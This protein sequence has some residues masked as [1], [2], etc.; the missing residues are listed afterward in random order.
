MRAHTAGALAIGIVLL[1]FLAAGQAAPP[2]DGASAQ[3]PTGTG[4]LRG[5]VVASDTGTP[6]RRAQVRAASSAARTTRLT[7]TDA[8]GRYEVANLP[9]GR[10]T[11][12]VN[13]AG[14]VGL[15]FG[16]RRPFEGG[17]P[18]DLTDGQIAER[19]DFALPRGSVIAGRITDEAGDPIVGAWVQPMR[20]QFGPGGTRSLLPV[21]ASGWMSNITNDLG[22]FR[23][24]GLMPGTYVVSAEFQ[25]P[26]VASLTD[27]REGLL[28]TYF[29]GTT[30]VAEAQPILVSLSE[31]AEASF[32]LAA[33]RMS[34]ISGVLR[35]SDGSAA[36]G[37]TVE[38][39]PSDT[40][41]AAASGWGSFGVDVTGS[42]G[43]AN[44][45]PGQYVLEV[46]PRRQSIDRM[47]TPESARVTVAIDGTD[48]AGLVITTRPGISVSGR[49]T[50]QSVTFTKISERSSLRIVAVSPDPEEAGRTANMIHPTNGVIEPNGRFE[51]RGITGNVLFRPGPLASNLVLKSV[52]LDG[53]DITDRPYNTANG[54][55]NG[56]EIVVAEQ[57]RLNGTAR[58]ARGEPVRDFRFALFPA[59]AKPSQLMTRFMHTGSADP[60][61]RFQLERLPAG[62]Y[63]G[64]AIESLERGQ[65]WDPAFQERVLPVAR[66]FA[67]KEGQT[68]TI[69]LPFVE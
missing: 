60:N 20:Y 11:I 67:L 38:L 59:R 56:L 68:L 33:G 35:R 13:K 9:A 24:F 27:A 12:S 17:R 3:A 10:Y 15:E 7:T 49:V 54:E 28:K 36:A 37:S 6:L 30:N 61:G 18:L 44:V 63:L 45:P 64:V 58:N 32:S 2:R 5:R 16:Q 66:R 41:G 57:A 50:F 48:L 40:S 42:F 26:G 21:E 19:I 22:E 55:L 31:E 65:E 53:T 39:R 52:F 25:G 4:R 1:P 29:P 69:D 23:V 43:F 34:R 51:L 8:E 47:Q 62:E 14:Y 46:D